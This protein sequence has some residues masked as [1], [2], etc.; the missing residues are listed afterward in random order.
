M[1][2]VRIGDAVFMDGYRGD[3]VA[4][5]GT[6]ESVRPNGLVTLRRLKGGEPGLSYRNYYL[7]GMANPRLFGGRGPRRRKG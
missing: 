5:M 1:L 2:I 7:D 3:G 6:V 4:R